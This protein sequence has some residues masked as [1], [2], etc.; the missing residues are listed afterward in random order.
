MNSMHRVCFSGILAA[1]VLVIGLSG[2]S[3]L[4]SDLPV[5]STGKLQVHP[6]GWTTPASANFH[7][8]D[9]RNQGWDMKS[10]QT[11]HGS[12]YDGG[13][14]QNSCRTCHTAQGGPESC[15]TCHGTTNPAPPRD[16]S[17]NTARTARGVGAHQLHVA[18]GPFSSNISCGECH[19]VPGA[20][21]VPGHLDTPGPAEVMMTNLAR[22][23]T[24]E[25]GTIDYDSQ[26]PLFQPNPTF[27]QNT[28][29]CSN[30]YCHGNFKNGNPET[31]LSW[32]DVS[33]TAAACGTCHGD[34]T[35]TTLAER[36]LPK[37]LALGGTHP[38]TT[39]C[40]NCHGEVVNA[41]LQFV[42]KALHAN[43]VLN[44]RGEK[45]NY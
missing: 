15:S 27:D 34:V 6:D 21:Y 36:A 8:N 28:L 33:G 5:P 45:R 7:G 42:D 14:A 19:Q 3:E 39:N 41:S 24:N 22:T 23:V 31:A 11:C 16:L 25:P 38:N 12:R 17:G 35:K 13:I 1:L 32:T 37:T 40:V 9:I 2:C 20:V 30:T 10:C 26:L 29:Q 44:F 43:G 18:G 4:N